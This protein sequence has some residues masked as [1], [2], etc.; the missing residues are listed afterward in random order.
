[1][2]AMNKARS[3]HETHAPGLD[4]MYRDPSWD[5]L[6]TTSKNHGKRLIPVLRAK[7]ANQNM[8]T[9]S[10]DDGHLPASSP[11][12]KRPATSGRQKDSV[13]VRQPVTSAVFAVGS[14]DIMHRESPG[15]PTS[16]RQTTHSTTMTPAS[17]RNVDE[18]HDSTSFEAPSQL[19]EKGC[20]PD[21]AVVTRGNS[22]ETVRRSKERSRNE[23]SSM[24][25]S[26]RMQPSKSS[27]RRGEDVLSS[28]LA[29]GVSGK[30]R[31]DRNLSGEDAASSRKGVLGT[32]I[33]SGAS[34]RVNAR[35]AAQ[36]A[37]KPSKQSSKS[38][39]SSTR[40]ISSHNLSSAVGD[41]IPGK[42]LSR[43]RGVRQSVIELQEQKRLV[44]RSAFLLNDC[45]PES[46]DRRKVTFACERDSTPS[47][48]QRKTT[49]GVEMGARG[50]AS[51]IRQ[52]ST[53]KEADELSIL[54]LH[55]SARQSNPTED[56]IYKC[57]ANSKASIIP[58][59]GPCG[60]TPVAATCEKDE[61]PAVR[62]DRL[63]SPV[64]LGEELDDNNRPVISHLPDPKVGSW[65]ASQYEESNVESPPQNNSFLPGN[66]DSARPAEKGMHRALSNISY[67][68]SAL[69]QV[70]SMMLD[71]S[72]NDGSESDNSVYVPVIALVDAKK[73]QEF[74]SADLLKSSSALQSFEIPPDKLQST[75]QPSP[76]GRCSSSNSSAQR[77]E[78]DRPSRLNAH[79]KSSAA[80]DESSAKPVT[81][82]P[83]IRSPSQKQKH[84]SNI[85]QTPV[86]LPENESI[87]DA[88][89]YILK[90]TGENDPVQDTRASNLNTKL[91]RR[92]RCVP[93]VSGAPG[94][95]IERPLLDISENA[96]SKPGTGRRAPASTGPSQSAPDL[97]RDVSIPRKLSISTT[98][99]E[100]PPRY[101]IHSASR[102]RTAGLPA[103]GSS[104]G[105]VRTAAITK[106]NLGKTEERTLQVE[107]RM[108]KANTM[109]A[110]PRLAT[111]M[112]QEGFPKQS[113]RSKLVSKIRGQASRQ[114]PF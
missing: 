74:S 109:A 11:R 58:P 102:P 111:S 84:L 106:Q 104:K 9:E 45:S 25:N 101:S 20:D 65:T 70:R 81:T 103:S 28:R 63:E 96:R 55:R 61:T 52:P 56:T 82:S 112:A 85:F 59:P 77:G 54:P 110:L 6:I 105:V 69:E 26:H 68:I 83:S 62:V 19:S 92:A 114:K 50:N 12:D 79:A 64:P 38:N 93:R 2:V 91:N 46:P 94:A 15:R 31:P 75:L 13:M 88:L 86:G 76:D 16:S 51:K 14:S 36:P 99:T 78:N 32:R 17:L 42:G 23:L 98:S 47:S 72:K 4:V 107:G 18:F 113:V 10:L 40:K 73:L 7:D 108:R 37:S 95:L 100:A 87:V 49:S 44:S 1:M 3:P 80:R 35:L 60:T 21:I 22:R 66:V 34:V 27:A 48:C 67:L 5:R 89:R 90:N 39:N 33:A 8:E 57:E 53:T 29:A 97:H 41:R 43:A 24:A 71:C 30:G